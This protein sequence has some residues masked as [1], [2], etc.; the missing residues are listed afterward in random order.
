MGREIL[1]LAAPAADR[2]ISY[3]LG[4]LH[5]GDLRLPAGAGP[6]PVV[7]AIHGGFWRA[8]FNLLYMGH[9]CAAL[10]KAGFATWNIEYRG[11]GHE[12]GGFPGTLRDVALA[13]AHLKRVEGLDLSRAVAIGHS[14]GGHLALWLAASGRGIPLCGAVSLAGVADL[15]RAWEL[16]LSN[17]VVAEFLGGGPLDLP[18]RYEMASPMRRLPCGVPMRLVHGDADETVPIEIAERF[19]AAALS[20]GDDCRLIRLPGAGHFE[21]VDPRAPEWAPV[22]AAIR[23]LL[24]AP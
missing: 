13:S 7:I 14:A 4:E 24:P 17:T 16:G 2:R 15:D 10:T 6:H 19:E 21:L 20:A 11:I 3:G 18:E 8:A 22:E 23:E 1:D 12:D 5:F 9:V